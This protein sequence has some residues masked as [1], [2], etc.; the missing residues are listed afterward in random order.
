MHREG[1]RGSV[2]LTSTAIALLALATGCQSEKKAPAP[3]KAH[4]T[5][6]SAAEA[7]VEA[8]ARLMRDKDVHR[9]LVIRDGTLQGLIT[10]ADITR[11]VAE[12]RL[13]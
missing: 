4:A 11:A 8:A 13:V 3:A 9:L 12:G 10:T 1:S 6:S 7:P 2:L 5:E